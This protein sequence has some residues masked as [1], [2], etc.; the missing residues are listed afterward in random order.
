MIVILEK[1]VEARKRKKIS[2]AKMGKKL[3]LSHSAISFI[4]TGKRDIYLRY[5]RAYAREVGCKLVL[6]DEEMIDQLIG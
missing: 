5:L 2:Q 6:L 1:L 4:E 3:G